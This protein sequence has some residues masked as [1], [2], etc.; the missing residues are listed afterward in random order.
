MLVETRIRENFLPYA[1]PSIGE[2]EIAEVVDSLRSGWITTG[3][4]VKRFETDLANYVG[5]QH[6]I[7]VNSCTAGLHVALSALGIRPGDEVIVPTL[8][9]CATA[10][11]V[12]HLGARPVLVDVGED[13]NI[14][15]DSISAAITARTRAIMPVHFAGQACELNS[16][17]KI[18]DRFQL[19]VIEDAAHAIGTEYHGQKIGSD[20]LQESYPHLKRVTV[21]S[22]YATKNMTTGEGGMITTSDPALAAQMRL[23]TL[24]G[25]NRDAWKRYTS[26]GSWFY[27]ITAAGYKDNMT[28]IQAA[29]GIHQLRRLNEFIEVRQRYASIYNEG[30]NDVPEIEVPLTLDDR[31]H[32]YHLYPIL[33]NLEELQI[34]RGQFIEELRAH[35]IGASV[36]FIPVHLHPFYQERFGYGPGD[37]PNAERLYE[38]LVSLPLYPAM[39]ESDVHYVIKTVRQI[40]AARRR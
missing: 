21:F 31:N 24:H 33:L 10:N 27:E 35:N 8:T 12:V 7:A 17:Y 23:L 2:A 22:F 9:F 28:D 16:I 32:V 18:A 29:L 15:C 26:S 4:K 5:T 40:I 3:P 39:E 37:L 30:F 13:F 1:L 38:R 19:A 11:V 6:A 34:D 20:S 36:H 25:M 14:T